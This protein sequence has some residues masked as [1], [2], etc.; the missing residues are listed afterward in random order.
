MGRGNDDGNEGEVGRTWVDEVEEVDSSSDDAEGRRDR[1]W[2]K[3]SRRRI[4]WEGDPWYA[5]RGCLR[6]TSWS[7]ERCDIV[8]GME[9]G[10]PRCETEDE[11]V[12]L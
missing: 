10:L 11:V 6:R 9:E 2:S 7:G 3:Y 5:G 12:A 4:R 8:E 1:R